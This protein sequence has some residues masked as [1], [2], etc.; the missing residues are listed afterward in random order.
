MEIKKNVLKLYN[1]PKKVLFCKN[2]PYQIKG[3]ELDLTQKVFVLHVN[4]L[5][6]KEKNK[7]ETKRGGAFEASWQT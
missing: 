1:L 7:L 3:Q 2:V 5:N 4:L 6:L